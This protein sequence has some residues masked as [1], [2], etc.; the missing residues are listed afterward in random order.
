MPEPTLGEIYAAVIRL[1][2]KQDAMN[3]KL[4]KLQNTSD[5]HWKRLN[6]HEVEIE[7]LKQRQSPRIHWITIVAGLAAIVSIIIVIL[8][9][10]Y[11][12]QGTTP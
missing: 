9:R 8:D 7:L 3:E 12:N 2:E 6:E 11:V 1:E 5:Q 4:E 10:F